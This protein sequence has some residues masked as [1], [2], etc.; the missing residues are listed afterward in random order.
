MVVL[1]GIVA[2]ILGTFIGMVLT[3]IM[4]SASR[5]SFERDLLK[6]EQE[7]DSNRKQIKN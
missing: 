2:F 5:D 4:A 6:K 3:S 1:V 7:G